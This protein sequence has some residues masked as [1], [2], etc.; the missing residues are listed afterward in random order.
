MGSGKP[1]PF[2]SKAAKRLIKEFNSMASMKYSKILAMEKLAAVQV[3][4]LETLKERIETERQKEE[5][6]C[7]P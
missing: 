6:T 2:G 1:R 7:C 5:R 4:L 3:E